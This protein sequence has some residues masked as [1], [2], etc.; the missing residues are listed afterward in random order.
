MALLNEFFIKTQVPADDYY[1]RFARMS[2]AMRRYQTEWEVIDRKGQSDY[3]LRDVGVRSLP[4]Q[5]QTSNFYA[6]SNQDPAKQRAIDDFVDMHAFLVDPATIVHV[7]Q[8][9]QYYGAFRVLRADL[10]REPVAVM[11]VI[12]T[13]ADGLPVFIPDGVRLDIDWTV[14]DTRDS[15]N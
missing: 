10:A 11:N 4:F 13:D 15:V 1:I 9:D 8:Q 12:G 3:E 6:P 7:T 5:I 14:I 2:G